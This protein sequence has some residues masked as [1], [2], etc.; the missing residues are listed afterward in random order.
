M[1]PEIVV[2]STLID[3]VTERWLALASPD[4]SL[5]SRVHVLQKIVFPK[6]LDKGLNACTIVRYDTRVRTRVVGD[7]RRWLAIVLARRVA[8]LRV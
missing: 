1:F 8:V 4:D 6:V 3:P 7:E 5:H 2:G